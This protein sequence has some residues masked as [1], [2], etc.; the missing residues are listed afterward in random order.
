[1]VQ[2]TRFYLVPAKTPGATYKVLWYRLP[3]PADS[4][5][6]QVHQPLIYSLLRLPNKMIKIDILLPGS[7]DLPAVPNSNVVWFSAATG[8][9]SN[10]WP[11]IP[12]DLLL[13]TK[14]QAWSQ[15]RES[16]VQHYK[17]RV[18]SDHADLVKLLD[19]GR[20]TKKRVYPHSADTK[21]YLSDS[22]ILVTKKRITEHVEEHP[23]CLEGWRGL[24]FRG[25]GLTK[26]ARL[27]EV[28]ETQGGGVE[29]RGGSLGFE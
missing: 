18:P 17:D 4:L 9:M 1:M 29:G 7:M 21:R 3:S 5:F 11:A 20:R 26:V 12:Y 10:T 27:T 6:R 25:L 23:E 24:G 14:L 28:E 15:R 16:P 22:F 13:M 8:S 2:N 19:I